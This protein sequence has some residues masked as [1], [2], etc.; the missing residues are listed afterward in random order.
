MILKLFVNFCS[1]TALFYPLSDFIK[2]INTNGQKITLKSLAYGMHPNQGT[3]FQHLLTNHWSAYALLMIC[4]G[5]F[6]IRNELRK[7]INAN[8]SFYHSK[9]L[10]F[11]IFSIIIICFSIL[12]SGSRSAF[13]FYLLR[14]FFILSFG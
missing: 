7:L 5:L 10:L 4:C 9:N 3:I 11:I 8:K 2:C 13:Y 14:P 6:L 12:F 1:S